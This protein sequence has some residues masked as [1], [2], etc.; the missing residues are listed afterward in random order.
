MA[1]RARPPTW[2]SP[3]CA[4]RRSAP[5]A[6]RSSIVLPPGPARHA[7]CG[8]GTRPDEHRG[9]RRPPMNRKIALLCLAP[10]GWLM[11]AACSGPGS[12]APFGQTDGALGADAAKD[13]HDGACKGP[14]DDKDAGED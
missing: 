2:I 6:R 10:A 8:D 5:I 7:R 14:D 4:I 13:E 3:C 1:L 12:D 11:A 9:R